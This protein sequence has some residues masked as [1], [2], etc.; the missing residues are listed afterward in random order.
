ML[1]KFATAAIHLLFF[2]G[3]VA[4]GAYWS[5]RIFTP[6]PMAAPPP[7]P[8][9]PLRDPDAAAAARMFGKVETAQAAVAANIQA[10]GAFAAGKSSSAILAVDGKPAR[11]YLVGQ[12]VVPGTRLASIDADVVVLDSPSGRQE[13]R[14]PPRP[15]IAVSGGAPA[16]N[17][18]RE[19]NTLSAPMSSG[20]PSVAPRATPPPPP[21]PPPPQ[22]QPQPQSP[23]GTAPQGQ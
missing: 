18:T 23:P 17:F 14:L 7:L 10:M 19:G 3:V 22:P 15:A 6:A 16:Q 1:K 12:E 2:A 13:V 20:A 5:V 11:V 8:P 9:P 4:I 21:A